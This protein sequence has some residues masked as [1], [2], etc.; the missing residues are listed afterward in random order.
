MTHV[1]EQ[2]ALKGKAWGHQ[3]CL[4]CRGKNNLES[5]AR[6]G[7]TLGT[8]PY[9]NSKTTGFHDKSSGNIEEIRRL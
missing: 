8:L 9:I 1:H 5:P 4:P 3:G 6:K 7:M 2:G